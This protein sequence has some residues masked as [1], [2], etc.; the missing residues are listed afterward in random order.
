MAGSFG[1]DGLLIP[2]GNTAQRP[3]SPVVGT[4]RFN[5]DTNKYEIYTAT[6]WVNVY[7]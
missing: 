3:V 6:G 5:T 7:L 1:P 2:S 4:L